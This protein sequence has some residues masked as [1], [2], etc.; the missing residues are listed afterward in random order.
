[1]GIGAALLASGSSLAATDFGGVEGS[2]WFM[3]SLFRRRLFI[4]LAGF[5]RM[6]ANFGGDGVFPPL[7]ITRRL[8]LTA[9]RSLQP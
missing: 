9:G 2:R 1:M 7:I 8:E 6:W 3:S 4:D 5:L